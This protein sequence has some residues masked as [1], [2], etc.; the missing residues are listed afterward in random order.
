MKMTTPENGVIR[1]SESVSEPL[2]EEG[3]ASE[4]LRGFLMSLNEEQIGEIATLMY[5]GTK[6]MTLALD[7][8]E[9]GRYEE[10]VEACKQIIESEPDVAGVRLLLGQ[11][12]SQ[13]GR[14]EEAITAYGQAVDTEIEIDRAQAY[15]NLGE[16]Y[17]QMGDEDSALDQYEILKTLDEELANELADLLMCDMSPTLIG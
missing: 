6:K 14:F 3:A 5:F 2:F 12:Y 17:L 9:S 4:Q 1:L 10:T 15:Y 16:T 11:A 7:H 8:F 13:M